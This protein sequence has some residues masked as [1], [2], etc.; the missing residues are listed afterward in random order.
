MASGAR[1][2][3][4]APAQ[5]CDAAQSGAP[6]AAGGS[7]KDA[8]HR[9]QI[10]S[11]WCKVE[12][13]R[14]PL[15]TGRGRGGSREVGPRRGAGAWRSA[16]AEPTCPPRSAARAP[17]RPG[18]PD[19]G[20][21]DRAR[22]RRGSGAGS[23]ALGRGELPSVPGSPRALWFGSR[24]LGT[25]PHQKASSSCGGG[26][27]GLG[28]PGMA[29]ESAPHARGSGGGGARR[30][31]GS[32]FQ[33][34]GILIADRFSLSPPLS[35]RML[36]TRSLAAA[37]K[38]GSGSRLTRRLKASRRKKSRTHRESIPEALLE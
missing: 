5:P 33:A 29:A 4:A 30:S 31:R 37:R 23:S 24:S 38:A 28:G 20:G 15:P 3:Q 16:A 18:L 27:G 32:H 12:G 14:I 17:R 11:D 25:A 35:L 9:P 19:C 21:G 2:P 13:G 8:R 6:R 22:F 1:G 34:R 10:P 26:G 36:R 7:L